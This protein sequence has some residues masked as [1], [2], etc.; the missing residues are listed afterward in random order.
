[1]TENPIPA[2]DC[3]EEERRRYLVQ[4]IANGLRKNGYI[5]DHNEIREC[6]DVAMEATEIGIEA[7]IKHCMI[8]RDPKTATVFALR[9]MLSQI[10]IAY[11]VM[12]GHEVR[13][14]DFED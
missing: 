12:V 11:G 10:P 13:L 2:K 7:A 1:M 3:S 8:S 14:S 6:L 4:S 5:P 9:E